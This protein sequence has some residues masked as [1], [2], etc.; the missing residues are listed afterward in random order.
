MYSTIWD[1][2]E[3]DRMLEGK[4]LV[5]LS[6]RSPASESKVTPKPQLIMLYYFS[7]RLFIRIAGNRYNECPL[8]G[9]MNFAG[10]RA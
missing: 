8:L 3:R 9:S 6:I 5:F 10:A 1:K 4:R 2:I 7:C